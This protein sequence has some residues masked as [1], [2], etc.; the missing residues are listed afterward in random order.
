VPPIEL[1]LIADPDA[2][3]A[4]AISYM[5]ATIPG[6]EVRPGNVEHVLLH[7]NAQIGAEVIEQAAQID[8]LIFAALGE[9]LL[10]IPARLATP[11]AASAAV[12]WAA[13]V[14]DAT[15]YPAGS[16]VSVPSPSGDPVVF[17]TEAD[18][19]APAGGGVQT[20]TV[21]ALEE[22]EAGNGAFGQAEPIDIVD[23]VERVDVAVASSGGTEDETSDDY[24]ARLAEAFTILA[25][26]P[27]LPNDFA[28]L[29]RQVPGVGR[30]IALDLYQP[31]TGQGGYGTPRGASPAT[32][33][34][35]CT[36]VAIT[37]DA[38]VQPSDALMQQVF[39]LLDGSREVNFLAFVIPP[40][41]TTID[42]Q[43]TVT[44]Y[45][46]YDPAAVEAAAEA[47]LGAW[48]D[49]GAWGSPPGVGGESSLWVLDQTVRLF[50]A[51]EHLN[52]AD[53]VHYVDS[54]QLR[55]Q[56]GSFAASDVAL[57]A[58]IGLPRA[59]A[60]AVTVNAP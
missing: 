60:F 35:R 48:L 42:V 29:A 44:A 53:G 52:R 23:G 5:E 41:Y 8:P 40:A 1:E 7:A 15:V 25:P 47:Q 36:T 37:A 31:S 18:L 14:D 34:P 26:R 43:A 28:I 56:G 11:A 45:P 12:T 6:F 20:V 49:P 33:V 59:G 3:A 16:L 57:D 27:I 58:P 50:E 32:D 4:A 9:D 38:G 13:D 54:V 10:G 24:L 46:G 30:A 21:I 2:M 55:K 22:G 51:V 39:E 17:Q 19:D